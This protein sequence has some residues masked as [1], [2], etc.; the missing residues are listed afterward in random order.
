MASVVKFTR[1]HEWVRV[2]GNTAA[3]GITE[4]AVHELGDVI[5]VELPEVGLSANQGEKLA[6][7]ESVKA[8]ADVFAPVG[9]VVTGVNDA[10]TGKPDLLNEDPMGEAWIAKLEIANMGELDGLMDADEYEAF[11]K[12]EG[13]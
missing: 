1:D 11:L 6:V 9:G 7:V 10:L 8:V 12:E 3:V 5:F 2:E 13:D 4:H